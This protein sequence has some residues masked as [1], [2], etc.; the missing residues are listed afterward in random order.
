MGEKLREKVREAEK[1]R[2][3]EGSSHVT[4]RGVGSVKWNKPPFWLRTCSRVWLG[5]WE[6]QEARCESC[7]EACANYLAMRL[8][9][10]CI[11]FSM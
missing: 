8:L 2:S 1:Q 11:L 6:E 9:A 5:T 4:G 7:C 10:G 3:R